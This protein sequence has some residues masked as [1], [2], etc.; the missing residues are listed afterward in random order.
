MRTQISV[1]SDE[2]RKA[3]ATEVHLERGLEGEAALLYPQRRRV[4]V[5]LAL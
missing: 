3:E 4:R 2:F 1:L 5:E